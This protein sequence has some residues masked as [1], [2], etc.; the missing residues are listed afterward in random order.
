LQTSYLKLWAK[1]GHE[2]VMR[3]VSIYENAVYLL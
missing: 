1:C 3:L 2:G